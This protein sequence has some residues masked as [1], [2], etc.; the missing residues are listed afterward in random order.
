MKKSKKANLE[1]KR[2]IF[3]QIG[4]VVTLA[5]VL[6]AFEWTSRID[7]ITYIDNRNSEQGYEE[8]PPITKQE[9]KKPP[10]PK[11]IPQVIQ[12][13]DNNVDIEDD[14]IIPDV[15][16]NPEDSIIYTY[17]EPD[18]EIEPVPYYA[19]EQVPVFLDGKDETLLKWIS[20][21]SKYPPI[22]VTNDVIG[23]VWVSFTISTSGKVVDVTLLRKVDPYLDA[24]AI[25]VIKSMPNWKPGNQAGR[26]VPVPYQLPVKF[27]L[28]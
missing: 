1:N 14:I 19:V 22:C 12:V 25:R 9:I 27:T 5:I 18:E 20:D 26:K 15:E 21:N 6:L 4:L 7:T 13:V 17:V 3:L 10:P 28:Y 24:E 16:V 23:T 8:L 2:S 11:I